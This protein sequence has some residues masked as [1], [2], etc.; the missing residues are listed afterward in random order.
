MPKQICN[1]TSTQSTVL[2]LTSTFT[3]TACDPQQIQMTIADRNIDYY[4][5]FIITAGIFISSFTFWYN[6]TERQIK[7][8]NSWAILSFFW[9]YNIWQ[10]LWCWQVSSIKHLIK[11]LILADDTF[12]LLYFWG[13]N[14]CLFIRYNARCIFR[15][16][17]LRDVKSAKDIKVEI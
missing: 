2:G 15:M 5:A 10:H 16:D 4:W 11:S 6:R 17:I 13:F 8:R 9:R 3:E 1:S 7:K 12:Q 14:T